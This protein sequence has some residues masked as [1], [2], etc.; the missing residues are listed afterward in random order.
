MLRNVSLEH[1][2]SLII[3]CIFCYKKECANFS[4]KCGVGFLSIVLILYDPPVCLQW[5]NSV[6]EKV[7][8]RIVPYILV[9]IISYFMP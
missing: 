8:L 4:I 2:N 3:F 6:S 1:K 5:G 7:C 9:N